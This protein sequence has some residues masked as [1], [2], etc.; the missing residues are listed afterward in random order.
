MKRVEIVQI[1]VG[2]VGRAVARMVLKERGNWL[3]RWDLDV[4]Y[5]A[6]A[7]RSGA[8]G[9][10]ELLEEAL[11]LKERG[12]KLAGLGVEPL[13]YVISEPPE[14]GVRRVVLDLA[15]NGAPYPLDLQ[16][17]MG[18]AGLVLSNKGP[19]SR[20]YREYRAL[21][22]SAG[23]GLRY[24]ATV[25][26]GLP[27]ISTLQSLLRSGDDVYEILASPSGTLGFIL[28]AV[29]RGSSFSGAVREAVERHYA[30]P[31]PRDDLSGLDVARKALILARALGRSLEP[32]DVPF[33]SL[34][35]EHL[36][37]VSTQEFLQR[38][39]E[40][41]EAFAGRVQAAGS[42]GN[43]LRYLARIPAEGPVEVGLRE[44][45]RSSPFSRLSGAENAFVFRTR[46]YSELPVTVTG[47]GA[48][49]ECTAS[50][51]VY[52]LLQVARESFE[53]SEEVLK[54]A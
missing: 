19:L 12:G 41:D 15:V 4:R 10:E 25:G 13:R 42:R 43:V 28:S 5:R 8:L 23:E 49:P 47:P 29:E 34:V 17:A 11:D 33:E 2:N 53:R 51:V 46:R 27:V 35:P 20:S 22:A 14:Y 3:E 44:V 40:A 50:G 7:D 39:E 31:D 26:A 54:R 37:E 36:V 18:G 32:E 30:E 52:D 9:G 6:V 1:G 45:P 48:G 21:T 38:L 24:E 16:A